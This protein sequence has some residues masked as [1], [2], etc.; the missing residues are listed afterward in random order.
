MNTIEI[1][2]NDQAMQVP[3]GTT[4]EGLLDQL[5]V[6]SPAIAVEVNQ[7]LRPRNDFSI[8]VLSSGDCL[9]IVTLV[10]GG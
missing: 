7:V 9:E 1:V 4:I 3:E 5:K 8:S 10:G 6:N 2:V